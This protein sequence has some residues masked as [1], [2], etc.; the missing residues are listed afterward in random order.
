VRILIA[1]DHEV[2]RKGVR[3]ILQSQQN[4]EVV[5]EATNGQE[6]VRKATQLQPDLIVLDVSMPILDGFSAAKQI[7]QA[8]PTVP[9]LM[10]SMHA[11]AEMV[12]A[13]KAAGAQGFVTKTEVASVLLK[14]VDALLQGYTCFSDASGSQ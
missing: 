8:L 13:S 11:G 6:A 7:K 10:L 4:L 5:G 1:D 2:V 14:A 3:S 9:I 12:R